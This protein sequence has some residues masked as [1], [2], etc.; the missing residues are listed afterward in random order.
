V[1][2]SEVRGV[3][4]KGG[5]QGTGWIFLISLGWGHWQK[6][7]GGGGLMR[8]KAL[9]GTEKSEKPQG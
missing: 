1:E 4:I 9:A 7:K 8:K 3:G 5:K 2:E 6:W